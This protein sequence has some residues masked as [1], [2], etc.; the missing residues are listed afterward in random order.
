MSSFALSP[1]R[2]VEKW[3]LQAPI[4]AEL[5][6][7]DEGLS[8]RGY[9]PVLKLC[10]NLVT[11]GFNPARRLEAWRGETFCLRV[12]AIGEGARLT[13]ADDR[14]G[15]PR[16]QRRQEARQGMSQ[17]RLSRQSPTVARPSQ[18]DRLP[19]APYRDRARA[20]SRLLGAP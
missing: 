18:D 10:R 19:W 16:L 14:H 3:D 2:H 12:R 11:A 5:I 7:S 4:R 20:P 9:A 17:V 1:Q 13:V 6:G 8:A 15:T